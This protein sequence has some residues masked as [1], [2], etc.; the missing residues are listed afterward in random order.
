MIVS[1]SFPF[2]CLLMEKVF[3]SALQINFR[4]S[5]Y[6]IEEG[7]D[8]LSSNIT[9]DF[10]YNQNLFTVRLSTVTID[11]AER[12]GLGH[13]INSET[14]PKASRAI[15]GEFF[16]H[17]IHGFQNLS[18]LFACSVTVIFLSLPTYL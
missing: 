6:S 14:I 4:E 16:P 13:F 8:R 17:K 12:M 10:R 5:D 15:A 11:T 9:L 7:S 18:C 1:V 2:I 3:R